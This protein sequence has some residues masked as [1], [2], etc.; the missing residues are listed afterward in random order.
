MVRYVIGKD[1]RVKE[2]KVIQPPNH[3]DFARA[4]VRA[5]RS[6]RFHPFHDPAN[7]DVKEVAHELTVQFRIARRRR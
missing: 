5:I 1:G 3:D 7:G 2:V 6:W 4:A